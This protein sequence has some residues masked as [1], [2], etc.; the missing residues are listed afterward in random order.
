M[1]D[2][3][4]L[5]CFKDSMSKGILHENNTALGAVT[6]NPYTQKIADIPEIFDL[7]DFTEGILELVDVASI[8]TYN[9]EVVNIRTDN[10]L[11]V[12]VDEHSIVR[13]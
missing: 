6:K 10:K 5:L 13:P 12:I 2:V 9:E 3:C 8:R 11:A 4:G 7:K 1:P